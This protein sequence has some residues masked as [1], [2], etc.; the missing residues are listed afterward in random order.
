MFNFQAP[1][2]QKPNQTTTAKPAN[3]PQPFKSE[4]FT[5]RS[6]TRKPSK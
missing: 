3:K 6:E 4:L 2:L 5:K 1:F